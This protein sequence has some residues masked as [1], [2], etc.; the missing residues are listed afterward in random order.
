MDPG[1]SKAQGDPEL[2]LLSEE[3][4]SLVS[5]VVQF[6]PHLCKMQNEI[7]ALATDSIMNLQC[8]LKQFPGLRLQPPLQGQILVH[9]GFPHGATESTGGSGANVPM[10][11]QAQQER[12]SPGKG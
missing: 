7:P 9:C 8:F 4:L 11:P 2:G 12:G 6:Q 3:M 5:I 10:V 1:A